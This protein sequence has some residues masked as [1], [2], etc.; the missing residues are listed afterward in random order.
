ME[1]RSGSFGILDVEN[2]GGVLPRCTRRGAD[3]DAVVSEVN[4]SLVEELL[5][6][7][8]WEALIEEARLGRISSFS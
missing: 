5:N 2:S 1:E 3:S 8:R 7:L 6:S 4:R